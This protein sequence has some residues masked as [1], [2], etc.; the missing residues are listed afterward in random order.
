MDGVTSS[1]VHTSY[2]LTQAVGSVSRHEETQRV[3]SLFLPPFLKN[4]GVGDNRARKALHR[5]PRERHGPPG[6]ALVQQRHTHTNKK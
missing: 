5:P 1:S 6:A 2:K 4:A 3:R